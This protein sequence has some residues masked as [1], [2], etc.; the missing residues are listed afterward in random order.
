MSKSTSPN[1][2]D[3]IRELID[4]SHLNKWQ[5][6]RLVWM[7]KWEMW[8]YKKDKRKYEKSQKRNKS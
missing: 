1:A 4:E 5:R 6:K 3:I 7:V 8:K 2:A